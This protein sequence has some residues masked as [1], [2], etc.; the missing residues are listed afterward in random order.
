MRS[1]RRVRA[2]RTDRRPSPARRC[3]RRHRC[4]RPSA[5]AGGADRDHQRQEVLGCRMRAPG[6]RRLLD[7]RASADRSSDA[8]PCRP[9]RE[10]DDVRF[11][12]AFVDRHRAATARIGDPLAQVVRHV[13]RA[14]HQ[15]TFLHQ[16]RECGADVQVMLCIER[17]LDRD[18][19]D[20]HVGLGVQAQQRHPRAVVEAMATVSARRQARV[21]AAVAA[22]AA[23]R[24]RRR[25]P[26]SG[27]DTAR[28]GSRQSRESSRAASPLPPS[29]TRSPSAPMRPG[30]PAVGAGGDPSALQVS[31]ARP[32]AM[33]CIGEPCERK[34][35]GQCGHGWPR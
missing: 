17:R 20:R 9:S 7:H 11:G 35:V 10:F 23:P 28:A 4:A 5:P 19:R 21:T 27:C 30:S 22:R 26:D 32:A 2:A 6:M 33:A 14:E 13:S 1:D 16:W 3:R 25:V 15:H 34:S 31:P 8:V 12:F 29:A 24:P 18:L